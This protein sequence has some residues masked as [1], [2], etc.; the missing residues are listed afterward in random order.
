MSKAPVPYILVVED[1]PAIA[2][3]VRYNLEK[4]GFKITLC[5]DGQEAADLLKEEHPDL[6]LMDWMLPG[7]T[8]VDL[9]RKIRASDKLRGVP[10][11]LLTAR[12]EESD[13]VEGLDSGADDYITKPFSPKELAARIRAVLRRIRPV[14]SSDRLEYAG[15]TMDMGSHKISFSGKDIIMGPTEFRLLAHFMESP[16]RTF[17]RES[18][19]NTVWGQDIY[20]ELRTVDVHIRRLRKALEECDPALAE[21]IKTVRS[22]GYMLEKN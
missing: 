3:L 10:I 16:G 8:G 4:E 20:V 14:F 22:A 19:L 9:C 2:T 5:G 18:L 7:L 11:I 15:I 13:R 17:S 21:L 1:D 12:G 6:I